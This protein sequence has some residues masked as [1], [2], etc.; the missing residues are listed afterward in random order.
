MHF[1]TQMQSHLIGSMTSHLHGHAMHLPLWMM[2]HAATLLL[3][4]LLLLHP[5]HRAVE[6]THGGME[7]LTT[8]RRGTHHRAMHQQ[9]QHPVVQRAADPPLLR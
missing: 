1:A 6:N 4:L 7:S 5:R 3:L 8:K 9:L 2:M